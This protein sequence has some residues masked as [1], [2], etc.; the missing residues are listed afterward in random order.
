MSNKEYLK[1]IGMEVRVARIR[2]GLST[3]QLAKL[4]GLSKA[5]INE[6]ELGKNNFQILT[7][8][9]IADVLEIPVSDFL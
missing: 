9:R 4:T 8:K 1:A 7:L 6:L 5:A 3:P 2:K